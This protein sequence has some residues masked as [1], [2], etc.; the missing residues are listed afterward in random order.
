MWTIKGKEELLPSEHEAD[1]HVE[2]FVY[3]LNKFQVRPKTKFK[4]IRNV[5]GKRSEKQKKPSQD[6][7]EPQ[8]DVQSRRKE[9][10]KDTD[11]LPEWNLF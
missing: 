5:Q 6:Y 9:R 2:H 1:R 11:K 4:Y 7:V 8:Q 3:Q 10:N